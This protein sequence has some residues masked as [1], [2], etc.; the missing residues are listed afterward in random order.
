MIKENLEQPYN[1]KHQQIIST[2]RTLFWKFGIKRVTIEEICREA[3]VSKMTFYKHFKNKIDLVKCIIDQITE[4]ATVKYQKIM[5]QDIPFEE[6]VLQSIH[7]KMEQTE[8]MSSEFFDD[9]YLHADP[10]LSK[11]LMEKIN[12]SLA[13]VLKDYIDAQKRGDIRKDIKPEF[14]MYFLNKMMDMVKD[15]QLVKTYEHPQDLIME[16]TNFFFYGIMTRNK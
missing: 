6:K 13:L 16:V 2:G 12:Y 1:E 9:Y 8:D 5:A 11:F 14:I 15:E 7:L 10:E 4:E 3:N